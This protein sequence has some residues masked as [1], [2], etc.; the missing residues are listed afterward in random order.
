MDVRDYFEF[1]SDTRIRMKGHRIYIDDV[2]EEYLRY[3]SPEELLYRFP[4]LNL[5]KIHAVLLYYEANKEEVEAYILRVRA[6]REEA[7]QQWLETEGASP[8]IVELR[9]RLKKYRQKLIAEGKR[10]LE[11]LEPL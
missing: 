7:Y 11:P 1:I 9:Q 5:E 8:R 3:K 4:T 2:L 6:Y 10:R